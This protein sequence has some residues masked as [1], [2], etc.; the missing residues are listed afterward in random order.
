MRPKPIVYCGLL[1][2]IISVSLIAQ[3][4]SGQ[5]SAVRSL[6]TQPVDETKLLVLKGNTYPLARAEYDQGPVPTSMA[7]NRMILVLKDSPEQ[8]A[9]LQTLLA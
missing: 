7:M 2:A 5:S 6:I 1:L 9:A 4:S 3:K 8:T